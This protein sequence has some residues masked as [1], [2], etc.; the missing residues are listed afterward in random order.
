MSPVID[1]HHNQHPFHQ[2]LLLG[3]VNLLVHQPHLGKI[4]K[5]YVKKILRKFVKKVENLFLILCIRT[6]FHFQFFFQESGQPVPQPPLARRKDLC[7]LLGLINEPEA[8]KDPK[9]QVAQKVALLH[10]SKTPV[11]GGDG[12]KSTPVAE[13]EPTKRKNLAKFFGVENVDDQ[14]NCNQGQNGNN[15][16]P[17]IA[18][19]ISSAGEG[20]VTSKST[21]GR[22]KKSIPNYLGQ[23]VKSWRDGNGS[24]TGDH[25]ISL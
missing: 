3:S 11:V 15:E 4:L 19:S 6:G 2:E 7:K 25:D 22:T 24:S 10:T 16:N 14:S 1:C 9:C 13:V 21:R 8:V 17:S 5:S 12:Q 18:R 20:S 23:L